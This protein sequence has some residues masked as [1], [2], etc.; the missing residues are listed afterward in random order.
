M[1][2]PAGTRCGAASLGDIMIVS[3]LIFLVIFCVIVIGH[4]FGHYATAKRC[5]IR[6]KEF[7]IGMG[8]ALYKK[9]GKETLFCVRL[10]P[11][12]GA[13]I[14]DGMEG[15]EDEDEY[16]DGS[17]AAAARLSDPEEPDPHAFPN[18]KVGAR[19][20]T[21]LGGPV[22]NFIL[23]LV[24]A[25][26]I[27]AFCGTDLPVINSVM[28]DS[29][30]EEAGLEAGDLITSINGESIHVYREVSLWSLVN[31]GE[32]LTITYE[33]DGEEY[34]VKLTPRYDEEADRYYIGLYGSGEYYECG[35]LEVFQYGYY[36][37]L[38]WVRATFKSL[39]LIF[40]GHFSADDLSGP[41]GIVQIVDE[42]YETTKSY[43]LPTM[44]LSFLN[45]TTLLS[46][47][48]G[49]MNL[50]P[51]PALDGGRLLLLIVEAIRGK[52]L[53]PKVEGYVNLAGVAFLLVLMVFV[54]FN[55]ITKFF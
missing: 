48:L 4:E 12:G 17:G 47:N 38:Y 10:L 9:Q 50:L 37:A 44:L 35:P 43:G 27:V 40:R 21:V 49:I 24:F 36:E 39:G 34:T 55:D 30:A 51:I 22:A 54:L 13:C 33:R 52:K 53:S 8:P 20:A 19:I 42:T 28:E 32:E 7:D 45:L 11:I 23:G 2:K 25:T 26:I 6:V 31:Y 5:G 16:G 29:A 14:F 15:W 46:I 41:V 18:A 1:H 3:I